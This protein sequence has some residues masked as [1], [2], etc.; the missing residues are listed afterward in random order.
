MNAAGEEPRLDRPEELQGRQRTGLVT[1]MFTD[2][3]G[4]TQLKADLGDRAGVGLIQSHHALVRDLL[5]TCSDAEEVSTAGDS[6]LIRFAKPSDAVKLALLLQSRL[7]AF[8][9]GRAKPLLER[10]GLHLGEVVI[11]QL[12]TGETDLLGMHVDVCARVMGLAQGAHILMTRAVFDSARQVL[13]G[14]DIEGVGA[15]S[16]V[17]HGWYMVKGMDEPLEVCEVAEAVLGAPLPPTTSDKAQ[18]VLAEGECV[19]GWR[20]AVEQVVP[21]TK[22]ILRRSWVRGALARYGKPGTKSS[23]NTGCSSFVFARTGCGR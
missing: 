14:Q 11:D 4:S 16:W 19:L 5:R 9:A 3:V 13:K 17:S 2:L 15:L 18:K 8:N 12:H 21:N 10:I 23:A 7:R 6:F 20:P 1:L 22:W